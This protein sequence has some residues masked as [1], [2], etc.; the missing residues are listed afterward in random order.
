MIFNQIC[1]SGVY[2]DSWCNG[3]IVPI[4]K[5]GDLLN[6]SNYR[7]ITSVNVIAKIFSLTLRNRLNMWCE[8]RQIFNDGQ[9]GF[10]DKRS[11][12][13]AIFILHSGIQKI[14]SRNS[15]LYC[16][17]IDYKKAFDTVLRDSLWFKL[18]QAGVSCK[19]VTMIKSI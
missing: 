16:I 8:E 15:K 19:M 9:F 1:D 5:K 7:G 10:R 4:H 6:P 11:T 13:D 17:F 18:E 12:T 2:P 3:V 14:L